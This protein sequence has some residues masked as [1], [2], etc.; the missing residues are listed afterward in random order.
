MRLCVDM[1]RANKTIIR[2]RHPIPTVHEVLQDMTQS[3]VFSTLDLK[4]G[5]H[6]LELSE[7]AQ[8]ITTF[9]THAGLCPYKRLMFGI[10]SAP[11][12]NQHAIQQ[13]LH[14]CEGYMKSK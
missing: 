4:W 10:T 2:E 13:V 12:R 14:G 5:Y 11:E 3:S 7:E 6:L 9:T 1:R 8:G